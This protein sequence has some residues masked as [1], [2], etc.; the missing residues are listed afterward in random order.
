MTIVERTRSITGGVDTHL[1]VHVAAA[2]DDIG[3]LLGVESFEA[4]PVGNDKLVCWLS[5]FAT[6]ARVGVEGTGSYGVGLARFL[7]AGGVDVVE[8]DHPNRQARRRTG[9]SDP[10]DAVE[11]ARAALSGRA[12]G[13]GKT[14]DGN[15]E[16]IRALVV[17]KRSTRSTKIRTLN[18]IRHLGF[19]ATD[20]LRERFWG[21]PRQH[22]GAAA[23]SLRPRAGSDPVTFAT[24]TA[25]AVLGRR[26]LALDEEKERLDALLAELVAQTAPQ[27]LELHGVGVDTATALLVAAG[28]N[29]DRLRSEAAWAHLCGCR[30]SRPRPARSPAGGSTEAATAKPTGP[31]GSWSS[32]VWHPTHA[33]APTSPVTS[34]K[35]S[36]RPTSSAFSSATSPAR[37]TATYLATES[38]RDQRRRP[39]SIIG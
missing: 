32:P 31:C 5:S 28:D 11:A 23:A 13:A 27:L 37:S 12:Q 36:P 39:G 18:Q 34:E 14:R 3:G 25:L 9:K 29:P 16:A 17:A 15:V 7:R 20:E 6:I 4:A 26:V 38:L 10:A 8:V 19:T 21:V 22:L 30:P 35:A 24:K 2:L 1:E 33:P